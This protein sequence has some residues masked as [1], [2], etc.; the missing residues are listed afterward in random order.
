MAIQLDERR[1]APEAHIPVM[2]AARPARLGL[3]VE[4]EL[5][6]VHWLRLFEGALA[7]Q[8]RFWGGQGNL[9]FPLTKDFTDQEV[10]WVLADLFDADAF[11]TYAPTWRE[12]ATIS[13]S[14]YNAQM[15]AWRKQITEKADLAET[16]RFISSQQP[17]AAVHP[18]TTREQITLLNRRL[19][20]LSDPGPEDRQLD[21]FNENS[22]GWPFTD[23]SEFQTLPETIAI[24]A[25]RSGAARQ[26]LLTALRGRA[27]SALL[28]ALD[29]RNVGVIEEPVDKYDLMRIVRNRDEPPAINP[30][31]FSMTGL[32]TFRT[33]SL[34]RL[35]SALVVGDSPWDFALFYALW[36]L[37][38]RAWWL[39]SWLRRDRAYAWSLA[40]SIHFDPQTEGRK[41]VV[42]STSSPAKRD[43]VAQTILDMHNEQLEIADWKDVLP[44]EPLRV[45][46]SDTPGKA[47]LM[48]LVDDSVLELDT[49][50]PSHAQTR[51]P[52][53]MRW[54]S[55]ARSNSWTPV[56]N[57]KLGRQLLAGDSDLVRAS[58]NGVAYFATSSFIFSG[59]SLESV[60]VRPSLRP[61]PLAE[62]V[63]ALLHR[64]GWEC[65][66]SDK[67]IYAQESMKLF[68]GYRALCDALRDSSIRGILN[69]YRGEP[70]IAPRVPFDDRRYLLYSHFEQILGK[71]KAGVVVEPLLDQGVLVRGVVLKCV[72]CRQAAW[73]SAASA[74][75]RFTCQRC[76]L[77]QDVNR[78]AWFGTPEPQPSYRLT[79]VVFQLLEHD[80]ELPLLAARDAFGDSTQPVGQGYELLIKPPDSKAQEIDIFQS[81]GYRLWIGEASIEPS[82]DEQRFKF[83][84]QLSD[85]LD[86]YGVLLATSKA[87]WRPGI[88]E[89]AHT[90]FP[91]P[92]P[93][94]RL[95]AGVNTTPSQP[96]VS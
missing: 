30:W 69:A 72:R 37:T 39:P 20:P 5:N 59:A 23:V 15:A 29:E 83:L 16:E 36:R 25:T 93:Q 71:G 70:D 91:G 52:A 58:R 19:S 4:A 22:V 78:D 1:P 35:P 85:V 77:T 41:A 34:F 54:I 48:P 40:S 14:V 50:L 31:D 43:E 17:E 66:T 62:Q 51:V 32:S 75:A 56:R 8:S 11:V 10:F 6:G 27:S 80:G 24:P 96:E 73:H 45:L 76:G 3:L 86:A 74:P 60:V 26:L 12:V 33:T 67:A 65:E 63:K 61:L 81:E 57:K 88:E 9:I 94:L 2:M 64:E 44:E 55:E 87:N 47:R 38:G 95:M 89:R 49:P 92:W 28:N 79:E 13:P 46:A 82:F 84:L 68:G 18:E 42:V 7:T 53:E 21:W 90:A